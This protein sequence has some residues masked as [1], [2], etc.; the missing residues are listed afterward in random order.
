MRHLAA[1]APV[2]VEC[3]HGICEFRAENR[4]DS[5][6][7]IRVPEHPEVFQT[8]DALRERL[9]AHVCQVHAPGEIDCLDIRR[10]SRQVVICP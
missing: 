1:A 7:D 9:N 8:G 4:H 10:Q 2:D 5:L 6:R 3:V